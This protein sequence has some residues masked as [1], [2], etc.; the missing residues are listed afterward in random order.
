MKKS[1]KKQEY[2]NLQFK[3]ENWA[4]L[5]GEWDFQIVAPV[6]GEQRKINVPFC[7]ESKASG[8]EHTD[9]I[10]ECVY[11][12]DFN[13][14]AFENK[15]V[16]LHFGAVY[17][18]AIVFVNGKKVGRHFGGYTPF[19]FDI[20]DFISE[21][22]NNLEV[23]VFSDLTANQPSGKQSRKQ[24]SYGC[25]YT[26]N[27]G[28]WQSVWLEY[29]PEKHI[30]YVKYFPNVQDCSVDVEACVK[31]EGK[32]NIDVLY[33]G[34]LVGKAEEYVKI[35]GVY[36]IKLSEKHLWEVGDGQ[37][38]DVKITYGEDEVSSY[39]GLREVKFD[40]MNFL[41][42]GKPVFQSFVLNQGYYKNGVVTPNDDNERLG[43]INRAIE[44]G[45]NGSR[46][47]QKVF[48]PRFLYLCD[49]AG[50][51]VWGEFASWGIKYCNLDALGT[52]ISE[53]TAVMERDFNH[54]SIILWCPLN[55][56]WRDLE[57]GR[58]ARD[59]RFIDSV[60]QVTKA[61]DSTRPCVDVSGGHHGHDTDLYD[62]HCYESYE[63]LKKYLDNL[64]QNGQLAVPLLYDNDETHLF[65][66]KG[67]PVN[68]SEFGG[69]QFAKNITLNKVSSVNEGAVESTESW[70]YG[71]GATDENAFVERYKNLVELIKSYGEISGFCYTQLYDVEQEE[72]GFFTY[73]RKPKL[74]KSA[75]QKICEYNKK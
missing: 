37:L 52:F 5:N 3:R 10:K 61:I 45:F 42:N 31:D 13:V 28:I 16:I 41:L 71:E 33:N 74:T 11:H 27:T 4:S 68:L 48:D 36:N 12:L 18:E 54:P 73:D 7:P 8:V 34:K 60:Y 30:E 46:L 22:E 6:L 51:M 24:H 59:V 43:D 39:F 2:Y 70:G 44:L 35:K 67:Q 23:K 25:F 26:R 69:I 17:Y 1:M 21:G 50:H 75:I 63:N 15:R 55:E 29:V 66:T 9:F 32:L 57:D 19:S 47:H 14:N 62:F 64:S 65:Y 58:K 53:W 56:T 38:Y 40:G 20:T 72:N 49:K